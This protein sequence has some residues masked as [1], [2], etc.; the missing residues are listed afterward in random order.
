MGQVATLAQVCE[1]LSA[2][3]SALVIS[4]YNPD[5]DAYGSSCALALGLK[6]LGKSVV[7]LNESPLAE[8]YHFIP[9]TKE[10]VQQ[11]PSGEFD[12]L[13]ACDC[14][15]IKRFGDSLRPVLEKHA[16][17][18]NIDHHASNT[19]FGRYNYV[20]G[21]ASSTSEMV[22]RILEQLKVKLTKEIA[23]AL[24]AG[25]ASDT[26]NFR[27][28]STTADTLRI[29]ATLV[30]AGAEPSRIG[31]ELYES[32]TA[33]AI[34]L[35]AEVLSSLKLHAG[36]K[37]AEIFATA[38][39]KAKFNAGA[40]DTEGFVEDARAIRGVIVAVFM[41]EDAGFWRVSMRSKSAH[42]DVSQ[43]AGLFGGG[44]HKAAAGFRWRKGIDELRPKL[45]AELERVV[46][47]L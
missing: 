11:V 46:Q 14:G 43:V 45:L 21:T 41:H 8:R 28:S 2:A 16:C 23:V 33:S 7:C 5:A 42:A 39:L 26:G 29:A 22:F 24:F 9:S 27:Y 25:I 1:Q 20:I 30:E 4:H 34:M 40:D 44:G 38:A 35:R 19:L 15:D 37:V 17:I 6:A 32:N 47:G 31:Q 10:V 18:L 12:V 13:A 3:K 36:G